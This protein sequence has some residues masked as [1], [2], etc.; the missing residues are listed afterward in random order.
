[1]YDV[2]VLVQGYP[3]RSICHGGLGWSTIALLRGE[4][5]TILVDVGAFGVRRELK[6]QLNARQV[7]AGDI[8]DIVITH[9]HYDHS[10]NFTLF[11]NAT[12]WIGDTELEWAQSQPPG[13]GPLP[14]LYVRELA[15]SSRVRR[16]ADGEEFLPGIRAIAA[17]GHTPGHLLFLL[18]SAPARVLFTGDAAKNR[19]ELLSHD[20]EATDDR[21]TARASIE[22]IW[23]LWREVPG[24]LLI[25]GHD[26]SMRLSDGG[27]P[28]YVGERKAGIAAWFAETIELVTEVDLCPGHDA[29][30]T[31]DA[32]PALRTATPERS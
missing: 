32:K 16:I 30:A 10:V 27:E 8:T 5:R 25:P 29:C 14:E 12:V 13:F 15:K 9:A 11:P 24:T 19:A 23:S 2:D 4:G 22:R 3:G 17:P 6:K 20:P 31:R 18:E 21:T 26:L 7:E 28:V 1:M